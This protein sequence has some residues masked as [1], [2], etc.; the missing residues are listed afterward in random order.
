MIKGAGAELHHAQNVS[1]R[2]R[3]KGGLREV[4]GSARAGAEDGM[5]LD[6]QPPLVH[7]RGVK[8]NRNQ[9]ALVGDVVNAAQQEASRRIRVKGNDGPLVDSTKARTNQCRILL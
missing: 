3:P 9:L 6:H 7:I 5:P 4:S 2:H 1:K 8:V